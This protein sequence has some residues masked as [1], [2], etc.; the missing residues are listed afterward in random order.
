[1]GW[2][3]NFRGPRHNGL[4]I[5]KC[6]MFFNRLKKKRL[7]QTVVR[8]S[9]CCLCVRVPYVSFFRCR[10]DKCPITVYQIII[11]IISYNGPE[12]HVYPYVYTSHLV[13][14]A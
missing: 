8:V 7:Q 14:I 1:M 4:K 6:D 3:L 13:L 2:E 9:S 11:I 10:P 5:G 12:N